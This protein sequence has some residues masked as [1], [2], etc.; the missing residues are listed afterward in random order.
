MIR[1]PYGPLFME[2]KPAM[3]VFDQK[4]AYKK[5]KTY[6]NFSSIEDVAFEAVKEYFDK[7]PHDVR[8]VASPHTTSGARI[9]N[10]EVYKIRKLSMEYVIQDPIRSIMYSFPNDESAFLKSSFFIFVVSDCGHIKLCEDSAGAIDYVYKKLGAV[11]LDKIG[12]SANEAYVSFSK[13]EEKTNE[14]YSVLGKGAHNYKPCVLHLALH[15]PNFDTFHLIF[16]EFLVPQDGAVYE[17]TA[18]YTTGVTSDHSIIV[19]G[20]V[21]DDLVVSI[22]DKKSNKILMAI[23]FSNGVQNVRCAFGIGCIAK[24]ILNTNLKKLR[25]NKNFNSI[26][27]LRSSI[28]CKPMQVFNNAVAELNSKQ[29]FGDKIKSIIEKECFSGN[30]LNFFSTISFNSVFKGG[31][32]KELLDKNCR[33]HNIS[34]TF[35]FSESYDLTVG[36][37]DDFVRYTKEIYH[38]GNSLANSVYFV[39]SRN[40]VDMSINTLWL[41]DS[42][43]KKLNTSPKLVSMKQ[44]M[45]RSDDYELKQVLI[46]SKFF[47]ILDNIRTKALQEIFEFIL[48]EFFKSNNSRFKDCFDSIRDMKGQLNE[49]MKDVGLFDFKLLKNSTCF[50][51]IEQMVSEAMYFVPGLHVEYIP[52]NDGK[53]N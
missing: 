31:W 50:T 40:H 44:I 26:M 16:S 53:E 22:H 7:L 38:A 41:Y 29:R 9:L 27:N 1:G 21:I 35:Q 30:N 4:T 28:E 33:Y 42:Q 19:L 25:E 13:V 52:I 34:G 49:Y 45:G 48:D 37:K 6:F 8:M 36:P 2:G 32:H 15:Q 51:S 12:L 23:S 43:S 20:N 3:D 24:H 10:E 14:E 18:L 17:N 11:I 39:V 46:S 5:L 47:P